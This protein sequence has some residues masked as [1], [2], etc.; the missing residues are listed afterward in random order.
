MSSKHKRTP[1]PP[2]VKDEVLRESGY[3][4]GNPRCRHILT[5]ELHHMVWVKDG[6]GNEATN[7]I[8]LC[9][10]CHSL[11]TYGH[12]PDSAIHHWKGILHALNHALSKES[13]DLLLFLN[14]LDVDDIWYSGDGLLKFSSLIAA[15]LVQIKSSKTSLGWVNGLNGNRMS[16]PTSSVQVCLSE[17]GKLLVNA[18][19]EGNE[20]AYA[21]AIGTKKS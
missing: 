17:R 1:I 4:C 12:I 14:N 8:A 20:D 5:L 16:S 2:S 11:H 3:M 6:G 10:N 18:W 13:M 21:A 19:L 15:D 9:P 7:L